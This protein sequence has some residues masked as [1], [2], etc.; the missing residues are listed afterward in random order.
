MAENS[1]NYEDSVSHADFSGIWL[2]T[3]ADENM[4]KLMIAMGVPWTVRKVA[5]AAGYGVGSMVQ[6]IQQKGNE[7]VIH[8]KAFKESTMEFVVGS[9]VQQVESVEGK[10]VSVTPSWGP[11]NVLIIE[12][13]HQG[14]PMTIRR[15]IY[16]DNRMVLDTEINGISSRRWLSKKV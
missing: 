16:V 1:N 12:S 13:I 3:E 9:G 5:A 15:Y 8:T 10:Q 11:N 4:E 2:L 14:K 7:M 6:T